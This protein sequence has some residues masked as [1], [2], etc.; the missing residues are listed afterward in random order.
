M[1]DLRLPPTGHTLDIFYLLSFLD[2]KHFTLAICLR[3]KLIRRLLLTVTFRYNMTALTPSIKFD[4]SLPLSVEHLLASSLFAHHNIYANHVRTKVRV[5]LLIS[6]RL[7][8]VIYLKTDNYNAY[9]PLRRKQPTS[10]LIRRVRYILRYSHHA[11]RH[12]QKSFKYS[13]L[14]CAQ[15]LIALSCRLKI[16]PQSKI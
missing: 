13:A 9:L 5:W 4:F 1:R 6:M 10:H 11:H 2:E 16:I 15:S 14:P 7:Q 8:L 12:T 3:S